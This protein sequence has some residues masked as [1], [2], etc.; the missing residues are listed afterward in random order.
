MMGKKGRSISPKTLIWLA[1]VMIVGFI[2][3]AYLFSGGMK[4]IQKGGPIERPEPVQDDKDFSTCP[5]DGDA[6]LTLNVQNTEN[7]TGAETYDQ[8]FTLI[9]S[10]GARHTGTDTTDGSTTVNC[11]EEY[12]AIFESTDGASGDNSEVIDV[13]QGEGATLNDDGT[14]SFTPKKSSYNLRVGIPQHATLETKLYDKVDARFAYNSTKN[15]NTVWSVDGATYYD[16]DNSTAFAMN[17]AGDYVDMQLQLRAGQVDTEFC[18]N[19]CL[20][21]VEAPVTEY[22]KPDARFEGKTLT[23]IKGSGLNDYESKQLANYE[24]VYKLPEAEITRRSKFFEFY[25]EANSDASTNLEVDLLSAGKVDSING[26]DLL[27][28]TAQDDSSSTTVYAVQ[29]TTIAIS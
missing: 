21:A 2:S 15:E 11:G 4:T 1:V 19:Y 27:T 28:S 29:N 8:D 10:G 25:I 5:D 24:Y 7:T 13:L 9:G 12:K 18:D 20:V 23:D 14:V 22:E 26:V 6:S 16:G 17:N 3:I